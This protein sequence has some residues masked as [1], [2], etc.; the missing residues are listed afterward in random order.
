MQ[1]LVVHE[2]QFFLVE[3]LILFAG[4]IRFKGGRLRCGTNVGNTKRC[5]PPR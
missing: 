1:M 3:E 5:R 2:L 4:E